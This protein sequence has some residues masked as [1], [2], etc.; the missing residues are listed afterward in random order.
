MARRCS[1]PWPWPVT[2]H[3]SSG[4]ACSSLEHLAAF[5]RLPLPVFQ[6]TLLPPGGILG[7]SRDSDHF[8]NLTQSRERAE[9]TEREIAAPPNPVPQAQ[10]PSG[11]Q[12]AAT[13]PP[14]PPQTR[15]GS[16]NGP[17]S[18][19]EEGEGCSVRQDGRTGWLSPAD[20]QGRPFPEPICSWLSPPHSGGPRP[21]PGKGSGLVL[22][23][24]R[25][26]TQCLP[27]E[28]LT[29]DKGNETELLAGAW[30]PAPAP[31]GPGKEQPDVGSAAWRPHN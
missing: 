14:S 5:R 7:I 4:G 11:T 29:R 1:R 24:R 12:A 26:S 21:G 25:H 3:T 28:T 18:R 6:E 31:A 30:A 9:G 16:I 8:H 22:M 17:E 27:A 23:E 10:R 20:P 13:H 19:T 2:G 15:D